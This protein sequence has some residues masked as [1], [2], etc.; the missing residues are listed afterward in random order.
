M[1]HLIVEI[2]YE[3]QEGSIPPPYHYEYT[4][5]LGPG[6]QGE[7]E[8]RPDYEF[9][10]PPIWK[11]SFELGAQQ[12]TTL[13]ELMHAQGVFSQEWQPGKG[14]SVGG[15]IEWVEGSVGGQAFSIPSELDRADA[16]AISPVYQAIR[17]LVPEPIW[18]G[19]MARRKEYERQYLE[20]GP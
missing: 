14:L 4:I 8:F 13:Y 3:W 10:D 11:A 15:S 7:I 5:R 1:A 20:K 12:L 9:N 19:L 6:L 17:A 2:R 18:T 16:A